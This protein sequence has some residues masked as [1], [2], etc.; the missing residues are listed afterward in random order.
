MDAEDLFNLVEKE[1]TRTTG[2]KLKPDK[3]KTN[4]RSGI[5]NS[6]DMQLPEEAPWEV[7][8][9]PSLQVFTTT[10]TTFL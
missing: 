8:A 4:I 1:R 6:A 3:F 7:A 5:V 10:I 2:W 9:S